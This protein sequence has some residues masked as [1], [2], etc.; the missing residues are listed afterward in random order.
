VA[1]TA[2]RDGHHPLCPQSLK[3]PPGCDKGTADQRLIQMPQNTSTVAQV[4][5]VLGIL[6]V[7]VFAAAAG[8]RWKRENIDPRKPLGLT[9]DAM[10]GVE[11]LVGALIGTLA[12]VGTLSV[13]FLSGWVQVK[14]AGLTGHHIMR[15]AS[16]YL[17]SVFIEELLC[18][19]LLL[20]GL[21][22]FVRRRWIAVALMAGIVGVLHG[23][24]PHATALST[25]SNALGGVIYAL[26]YLDS[27]RL[28][29]GTGIHFAWNFIQGPVLGFAVSG[30]V[31]PWGGLFAESVKGPDW[32]TGGPFG[33]EG[34][35]VC[36]GFRI[37][38]A[39][40][41]LVWLQYCALTGAFNCRMLE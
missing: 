33:P 13:E 2:D 40:L 39:G 11:F 23:A 20:S 17:F 5:R 12:M 30:G 6:A 22:M 21:A 35:L 3:I 28:W 8:F 16:S 19:G 14:A 7:F 31:M 29:L 1:G 9:L 24:N 18:R 26:A 15:S 41:I 4:L 10:A 25:F 32:L 34:G 36:V 27:R 37:V 38:V